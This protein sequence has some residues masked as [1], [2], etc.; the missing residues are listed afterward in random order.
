MEPSS[1]VKAFGVLES[2]ADR[3]GSASLAELSTVVDIPKATTHRILHVLLQMGYVGHESGGQY[4]LT[5]KLRWIGLGWKDRHLLQFA[6][7]VLRDLHAETGETIN[8]GVL[9]CNRVVYLSVIESIHPLR[10]V[11]QMHESDPLFCTAL[12]RAMA[13]RLPRP[14]LEQLLRSTPIESR[15]PRTV[16]D[17][18]EL[19]EIV[20]A[21]GRDGYAVERDQTDLGVT[22]I[23]CPI[24]LANDPVAAVSLS[25]PTARI[26]ETT[27]R[28]L[29]EKVTAAAEKITKLIA[30]E[31]RV[32]A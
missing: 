26:N 20:L 21:A 4:R 17:V 6:D 30:A 2:L 11:A 14:R 29:I 10:R 18:Q 3:G 32:S 23:A 16:T 15:T 24:V 8:L 22:C 28:A 25:A 19:R 27:E 5:P 31:E 13:S 9:R 7:P 1:L 12:G